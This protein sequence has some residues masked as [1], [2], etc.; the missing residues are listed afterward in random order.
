MY[1]WQNL[2]NQILLNKINHRFLVTIKLSVYK[3]L[4][5]YSLR[6]WGNEKWNW[7]FKPKSQQIPGFSILTGVALVIKLS[8]DQNSWILLIWQSGSYIH[9]YRKSL[10]WFLKVYYVPATSTVWVAFFSSFF[11]VAI[12]STNEANKAASTRH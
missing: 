1:F 4:D 5:I 7:I 3:Y 8:N 10:N 11:A 9:R 12:N 6:W 2:K